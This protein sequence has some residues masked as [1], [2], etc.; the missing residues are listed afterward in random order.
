M[1]T[2]EIIIEFYLKQILHSSIERE[3]PVYEPCGS[4]VSGRFCSW[5]DGFFRVDALQAFESYDCGDDG[6]MPSPGTKHKSSLKSVLSK[7]AK[8]EHTTNRAEIFGF[9]L[10]PSVIPFNLLTRSRIERLT[11]VWFIEL[12]ESW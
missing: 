9:I 3:S 11:N 4:W 6:S 1:A 12:L 8:R 5:Q 10:S 2:Q 7:G